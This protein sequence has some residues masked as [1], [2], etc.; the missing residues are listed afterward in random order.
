MNLRRV[1][2]LG[3]CNLVQGENG[4]LLADSHCIL[5]TSRW[6]N[7]FCQLLNIHVIN[8]DRQTEIHTT[9]LLVPEPS[10]NEGQVAIEKLKRYISPE[11]AQIPAE[12]IQAGGITSCVLS[13]E[14][15]PGQWKEFTIVP[16][17]NKGNSNITVVNCIQN[18]IQHSSVGVNA[19]CG[20][21]YWES[22]L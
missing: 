5:N 21:N 9:E 17:Y 2:S 12:L 7:Y 8:D 16:V 14:E 18:F 1:T 22:S 15:F 3:T 4:D 10:S 19:L 11:T 6:K 13:K 20:Q